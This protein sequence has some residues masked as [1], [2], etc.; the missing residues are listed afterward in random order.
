MNG[1]LIFQIAYL[2]VVAFGWFG[3]I[4]SDCGVIGRKPGERR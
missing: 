1:E 3:Y 2:A 4:L